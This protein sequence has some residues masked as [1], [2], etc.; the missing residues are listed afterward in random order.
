MSNLLHSVIDHP[1]I[2]YILFS[3]TFVGVITEVSDPGGQDLYVKFVYNDDEYDY[4]Y[5]P[6]DSVVDSDM[7]IRVY[8]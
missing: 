5:I 6:R 4:K 3:D 1:W 7:V 2:G 8:I